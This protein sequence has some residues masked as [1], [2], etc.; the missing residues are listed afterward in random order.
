MLTRPNKLIACGCVCK[1]C[2]PNIPISNYW[3]AYKI[4]HFYII[5]MAVGTILNYRCGH[6]PDCLHVCSPISVPLCTVASGLSY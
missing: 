4:L 2:L 6:F 1:C 3:G 5:R